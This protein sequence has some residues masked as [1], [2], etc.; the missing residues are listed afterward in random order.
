M[1]NKSFVKPAAAAFTDEGLRQY[2]IR[3]YNFM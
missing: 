3:V 2:M 1:E